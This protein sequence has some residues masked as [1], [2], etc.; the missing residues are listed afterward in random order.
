MSDE[1]W[2]WNCITGNMG[3]AEKDAESPVEN[4]S[5]IVLGAYGCLHFKV[6]VSFGI[7]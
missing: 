6:T 5:V 7:L 3:E 1:Q 2:K 4:F